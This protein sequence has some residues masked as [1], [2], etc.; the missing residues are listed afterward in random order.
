MEWGRILGIVVTA[1]ILVFAFK[2]GTMY[3]KL[4]A[5]EE[6]YALERSIE[7]VTSGLKIAKA[8]QTSTEMQLPKKLFRY[9]YRIKF[10]P[11][12]RISID[13]EGSEDPKP[14]DTPYSFVSTTIEGGSRIRIIK[15]ESLY[16]V[17]K[18]G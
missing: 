17:I 3:M 14:I 1:I 18:V 7:S 11:S 9:N 6:G 12:G 2:A 5:M 10:A 13:I 15:N 4:K 16:K 8:I